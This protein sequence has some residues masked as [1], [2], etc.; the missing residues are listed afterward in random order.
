MVLDT[1]NNTLL[2]TILDSNMNS[3]LKTYTITKTQKRILLLLSDN[4][5]HTYKELEEFCNGIYK[6]TINLLI[7][8]F[9]KKSLRFKT[10]CGI[11]IQL[12]DYVRI[13]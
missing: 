2:V 3:E 5:V 11:G 1:K 6:R 7:G 10:R 9:K 13:K 4:E 8:D 12:L